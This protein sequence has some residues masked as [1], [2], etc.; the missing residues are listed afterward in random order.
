MQQE[1]DETNIE[2]YIF[3]G[4]WIAAPPD[5]G[6]ALV[7]E[8]YMPSYPGNPFVKTKSSTILPT[9]EHHSPQG[10]IW[11]RYVGGRTSDKMVEVFGWVMTTGTTARP[12]TT[13]HHLQQPAVLDQR[14]PQGDHR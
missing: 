3:G 8:A 12:A 5:R 9:V 1:L 13:S 7:M 2:K 6:D 4:E 14:H 11:T 10:T